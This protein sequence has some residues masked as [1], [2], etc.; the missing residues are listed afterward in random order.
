MQPTARTRSYSVP[1]RMMETTQ[2]LES[3]AWWYYSG[4]SANC[5]RMRDQLKTL[6]ETFSQGLREKA[7]DARCMNVLQTP[8]ARNLAGEIERSAWSKGSSATLEKIERGKKTKKDQSLQLPEQ[9]PEDTLA[10]EAVAIRYVAFIRYVMLHLKNQLSFMI[11]GFIL[12]AISLNCYPFQGEGYFGWWL[13]GIFLILSSTSIL[14]FI[15]MAHDATLSN[16]TDTSA[17]KLDTDF[18][19]KVVSAGTL[20]LLTLVSSQFPDIGRVLFSWL[21]PALSALH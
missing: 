19:F 14:V 6:T 9:T 4:L 1:E 12:L 11:V 20:P 3:R 13:T 2:M 18:Y 7:K 17:G 15:E 5:C 8:V 10:A 16:L 21:Q